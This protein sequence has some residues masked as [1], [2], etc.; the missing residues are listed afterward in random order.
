MRFLSLFLLLPATATLAGVVSRTSSL[1]LTDD[2]AEQIVSDFS[3]LLG[4]NGSDVAAYNAALD[5]IAV[6]AYQEVSDSINFLSGMPLGSVTFTSRANDEANHTV[7]Q[8]IFQRDTLNI[9]HSC[10][11][12]TWRWRFTLFPGA[13]PVQGI[14][15]FIVDDNGMLTESFLEF[16]SAVWAIDT[17]FTVTP[18]ATPP[19]YP[20]VFS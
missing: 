14:N 3:S 1:C 19:A 4:I 10:H 11:S 2:K 15:I 12:I 16:N 6:P 17:G 13:L 8:A 5:A 9:F 20:K 18:P 7:A